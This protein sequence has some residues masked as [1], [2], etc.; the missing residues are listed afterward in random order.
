MPLINPNLDEN[1]VQGYLMQYEQIE[2]IIKEEQLGNFKSTL[3][4]VESVINSP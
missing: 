2:N 1:A 3:P 4:G